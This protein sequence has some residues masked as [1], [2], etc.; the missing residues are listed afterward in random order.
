MKG[1]ATCLVI[2]LLATGTCAVEAR[3]QETTGKT[4]QTEVAPKPLAGKGASARKK[5]TSR[6]KRCTYTLRNW[7]TRKG[8]VQTAPRVDKPYREVTEDERDPA[9]P[10]CTLCEVDQVMINP[11]TLGLKGVKP[12]RICRHWA[13]AVK[14]ALRRIA[15][16]G[17]FKVIEIIGYRP[18]RTRGPVVNGVRTVLS[19]HSYGTA[20]DIN[21]AYNGLYKKCTREEFA[22][23]GH[24]TCKLSIGGKWDPTQRPDRT[25][26]KKSSVYKAFK[27]I[28]WKWGGRIAGSTRD[29]MHFS[30]TGY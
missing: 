22:L 2:G 26:T 1:L 10:R 21:P 18:G 4:R 19:N 20:I 27:R 15:R 16:T 3:A 7:N 28:G 29:M 25:I 17:D 23:D 9:D 14:D 12:F 30:I 24:G 6:Y 8:S 11:A 5:A 13:P